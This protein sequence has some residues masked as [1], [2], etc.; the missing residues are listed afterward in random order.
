MSISAIDF[1]VLTYALGIYAAIVVSP[2]RTL[3]SC[4]VSLSKDAKTSVRVQFWVSRLQQLSMRSLPWW[5]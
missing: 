2:G 4:Y 3:R 1:A 5:A